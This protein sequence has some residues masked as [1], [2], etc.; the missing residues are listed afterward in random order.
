MTSKEKDSNELL[1]ILM[2][3]IGAMFIFKAVLE[4]MAYFGMLVPSWLSDFATNANTAAALSMFQRS[5]KA[6]RHRNN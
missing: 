1:N 5:L 3:I 4:G 6:I 2:I